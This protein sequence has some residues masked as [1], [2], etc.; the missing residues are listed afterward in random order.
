MAAQADR[1][2]AA[3]RRSAVYARLAAAWQA[4]RKEFIGDVAGGAFAA[5]LEADVENLHPGALSR[6]IAAV[7]RACDAIGEDPAANGPALEREHAR[8]FGSPGPRAV[9][10]HESVYRS[11]DR[12]LMSEHA[13]DVRRA[14]EAAGLALRS[15]ASDMPDAIDAE[16]QFMSLLAAEEAERWRAGRARRAQEV[17]SRATDF[18]DRHLA[19]WTPLFARAMAQAGA[20]AFPRAMADLVAAF[21]AH[22]LVA[23]RAQSWDAPRATGGG[24]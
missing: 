20:S 13:L 12:L 1:A 14:F 24:S 10:R 5:A 22:D 3:W 19:V 17:A 15:D 18:L 8:L 6:E 4:P 2:D 7:W 23:L 21:V 9:P 16:L 11:P